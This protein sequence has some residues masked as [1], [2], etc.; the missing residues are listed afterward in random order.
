MMSSRTF[1]LMVAACGV[2]TLMACASENAPLA[3]TTGAGTAATDA[4]LKVSAPSIVSPVAGQT[5]STRTPTLVWQRAAGTYASPQVSYELQVLSPAGDLVYTRSVA[6][7]AATGQGT[8]SHVIEVPL[9]S[10]APYRWRVRAVTGAD[11][12]PWSD[13]PSGPTM[14]STTS[15]T[16][17]SSNDDFRDWFFALVVERGVATTV[18]QPAMALLEPDFV[19]VGIIM[20]KDSSGSIRGRIYL[21][22][23]GAD[24]YARSV[25]VVSG[26]G[27]GHRWVWVPRG[28]TVCEGIC[29]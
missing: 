17:G 21:P 7:G 12:G 1:G 6:G 4:T 25:D 24:R 15:L 29:P 9:A 20:A 8:L 27:P 3:P 10:K 22:T 16:P 28:R 19:S 11:A 18:T 23:N 14:F 13:Q 5:L 2:L 26:F